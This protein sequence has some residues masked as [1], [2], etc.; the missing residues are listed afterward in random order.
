MSDYCIEETQPIPFEIED[1]ELGKGITWIY[2]LFDKA[3]TLPYRHWLKHKAE[4]AASHASYAGRV[5]FLT[6]ARNDPCPCGC[7]QK[8]KKC[9]YHAH[10]Q[11]VAG[12][13]PNP[14]L[15]KKR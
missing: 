13:Q 9:E 15:Y 2:G 5:P 8:A 10:T 14:N 6:A 11:Q 1:P 7:G 4:H 3:K 12:K